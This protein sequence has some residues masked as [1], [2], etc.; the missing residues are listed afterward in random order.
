MV[1]T[2]ND[3]P[4]AVSR[5]PMAPLR[6]EKISARSLLSLRSSWP[7][8]AAPLAD[9]AVLNASWACASVKKIAGLV[10]SEYAS[11]FQTLAYSDGTN[12]A[13]F[14]TDAQAQDAF[15]TALS[16]NGAADGG[17]LDLSDS[18]D[19]ALIFSILNGAIGN[20]ETATGMSFSV[21]T[22]NQL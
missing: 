20:L 9:K 17:Q 2:L 5:L 22:M 15:N 8:S 10:P 3:M 19:R 12:P 18:N 16:A 21:T 13:I 1:V 14:F 7:P 4:V 6:I 11:V